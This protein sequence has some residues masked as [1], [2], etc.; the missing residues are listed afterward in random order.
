M[1]LNFYNRLLV[2][3]FRGQ[4]SHKAEKEVVFMN[5]IYKKGFFLYL[6]CAVIRIKTH[7]C[8]KRGE[9]EDLYS[10]GAQRG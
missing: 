8:R 3:D 10:N 2:V 4:K 6:N 7:L 9:P 5:T 1:P